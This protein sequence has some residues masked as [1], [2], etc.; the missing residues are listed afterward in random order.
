L[1]KKSLLKEWSGIG[2]GCPGRWW[3]H[4]PRRCSKHV[5]LQDMV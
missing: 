4:Q 3:S 2:T 1:G 5:A